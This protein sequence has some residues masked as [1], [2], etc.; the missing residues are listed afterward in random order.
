MF[1]SSLKVF[2][3]QGSGYTVHELNMF[4]SVLKLK[5]QK[6]KVFIFT[7]HPYIQKMLLC[8]NEL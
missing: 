2:V 3:F 7:V 4:D 5:L 1:P 6:E 8:L